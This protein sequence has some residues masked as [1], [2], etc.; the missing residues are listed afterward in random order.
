MRVDVL[1]ADDAVRDIEEIYR[2][3]AHAD[4][5][6]N[7]DR[8]IDALEAVCASLAELPE[9]GDVPRELASL[10]I[11]EYRELHYK[12]YRVI[13]R[14]IGRRVIVYGVFDGRRDMRSLLERRLIR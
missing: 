10:G 7:A 8:L 14:L 4:S 12:P 13:Y 11:G 9:R 1:M 2:Y 6:E 5:R 3:V